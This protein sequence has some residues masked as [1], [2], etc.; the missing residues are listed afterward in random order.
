MKQSF[1]I[2]HLYTDRQS[3]AAYVWEK[4]QSILTESVLDVGADERFLK[5]HLSQ[6]KKYMGV[7][8]GGNPDI[9]LDLEKEKLPFKKSS[10]TT[11]ICLDVLEH[12]NNPHEVFDQLCAISKK[13]VIISLPNAYAAFINLLLRG[14]Y[15]SD[16]PLKFYGIPL[17]MPD[18]RHKW[19]FS[20]TEAENFIRYRAKK[21]KMKVVQID[22]EDRKTLSPIEAQILKRVFPKFPFQQD[23]NKGTLWAVL[24]KR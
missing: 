18:D 8:I 7:G 13:Y 22:F 6:P 1:S 15:E 14:R 24:K 21:N 20:A 5:S 23:L 12:I 16:K 19:F 17:E 3:K 9:I 11:V 10:F 2:N 4:Y